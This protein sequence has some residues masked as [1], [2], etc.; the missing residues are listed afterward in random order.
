MG[1]HPSGLQHHAACRDEQRRPGGIGVYG[2][3]N[4]SASQLIRLRQGGD[5]AGR[6]CDTTRADSH[7]A[8]ESPRRQQRRTLEANLAAQKRRRQTRTVGCVLLF[9]RSHQLWHPGL[10]P[11][12]A[13]HPHDLVQTQV[14][15]VLNSRQQAPFQEAATDFQE[16]A[17]PAEENHVQV[18]TLVLAE[19]HVVVCVGKQ[20]LEE[21]PPWPT[22][23]GQNLA[24][25]LLT[26]MLLASLQSVGVHLCPT[27]N[28]PLQQTEHYRRIVLPRRAGNVARDGTVAVVGD[29]THVPPQE[30]PPL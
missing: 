2:D 18:E 19:N 17:P 24:R 8:Q 20:E 22:E 7:A 23:H 21:D 5:D 3:Q 4:L 16:N 25:Y 1:K 14:E 9:T 30:L 28:V 15:H 10:L 26:L 13:D 12:L 27:G 11:P 6:R 29:E